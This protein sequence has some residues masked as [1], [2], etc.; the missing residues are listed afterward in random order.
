[1]ILLEHDEQ[2]G[3]Y[4]RTGSMEPIPGFTEHIRHL[5]FLPD[6]F[7]QLPLPRDG[8]MAPF[9]NREHTCA[10]GIFHAEDE[11]SP[12]VCLGP[13]HPPTRVRE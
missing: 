10:V 11:E 3:V 6:S 1:M 2:L 13:G 7:R 12:V 8:V 5:A 4:Y 9:T